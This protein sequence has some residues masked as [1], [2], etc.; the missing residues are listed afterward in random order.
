MMRAESTGLQMAFKISINESD[1][2]DDVNAIDFSILDI[3]E[4]IEG[5]QEELPKFY[6]PCPTTTYSTH[7]FICGPTMLMLQS[8]F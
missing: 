2:G 7:K 4:L 1:I 3:S 8:Q 6:F 5:S